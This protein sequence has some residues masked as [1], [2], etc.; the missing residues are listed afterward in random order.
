ML[1]HCILLIM[2]TAIPN[3][4]YAESTNLDSPKKA[5]LAQ[6]VGWWTHCWA[7]LPDG[8]QIVAPNAT[9]AASCHTAIK[10][11]NEDVEIDTHFYKDPVVQPCGIKAR[12]CGLAQ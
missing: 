1:K 3:A 4:A 5:A 2:L 8:S 7:N 10:K 6:C 12:S 11:C 9:D